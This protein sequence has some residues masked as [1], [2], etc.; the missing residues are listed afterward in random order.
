MWSWTFVA[1]REQGGAAIAQ[2]LIDIE[3]TLAEM[4]RGFSKALPEKKDIL[5][6]ELTLRVAVYGRISLRSNPVLIL[7]DFGVF[8]QGLVDLRF[9]PEIECAFRLFPAT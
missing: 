2:R 1:Q 4:L 3:L 8:A 9:C 6:L 5:S 7:K